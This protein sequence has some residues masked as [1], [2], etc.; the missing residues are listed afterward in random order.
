MKASKIEDMDDVGEIKNAITS[1]KKYNAWSRT[2][3]LISMTGFSLTGLLIKI[4]LSD[5]QIGSQRVI[6]QIKIRSF[7]LR[8]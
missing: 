7:N 1:I 3:S 5:I 8:R 4:K 2:W 6:I